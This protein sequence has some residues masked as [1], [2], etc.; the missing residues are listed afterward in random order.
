MLANLTPVP[1]ATDY[2]SVSHLDKRI[3]PRY[4][5]GTGKRVL[6]ATGESANIRDL[7]VGGVFIEDRYPPAIGHR[8][9]FDM[10]LSGAR[11]HLSGVVRRVV[12]GKGAGVQ[13]QNLSRENQEMLEKY[14][15]QL[16]KS[17][18]AS[19]APAPKAPAA[20]TPSSKAA[21][22]PTPADAVQ[23]APAEPMPQRLERLTTEL[24][25]LETT[26]KASEVEGRVLAE[27]RHSVDQIRLTAWAVQQWVELEAQK[28]D[29]YGV[30]P[31]LAQERAKRAVQ[32]C[33]D[34]SL[35]IDTAD[36]T[37]EA[38]GLDHLYDAVGGLYGRLA[39][40][41]KK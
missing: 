31:I 7:S 35:D 18:P 1:L 29:A 40:I 36:V 3:T 37:V 10:Y 9:E 32:L 41:F 33:K 13:F 4:P 16:A 34:L 39:R 20:S 8:M 38:E 11:L 2:S 15:A 5:V 28:K 14:V 26:I 25:E 27:F 12:P 19:A 17:A 23:A 21:S 24:R 22:Q 6:Y 30:L